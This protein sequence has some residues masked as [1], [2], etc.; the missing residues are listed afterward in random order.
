MKGG[1]DANKENVENVIKVNCNDTFMRT[2]ATWRSIKGAGGGKFLKNNKYA[3]KK[4]DKTC[5][6]HYTNPTAKNINLTDW[7]CPNLMLQN[8]NNIV[9]QTKQ[10]PGIRFSLAE[11]AA[12]KFGFSFE[13]YFP[14][15][16][17]FISRFIATF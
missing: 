1:K 12:I 15:P 11:V 2:N 9:W 16:N 5:K 14:R 8:E 13:K 6:K 3:S 7:I 10:L 4:P 17:N